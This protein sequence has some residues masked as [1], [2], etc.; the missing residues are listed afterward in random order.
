MILKS[1]RKFADMKHVLYEQKHPGLGTAYWV[2]SELSKGK[3]FNMTILAPREGMKEFPKTFGHYHEAVKHDETETYKL[4]SGKGIF[5]LQKKF[6]D[7]KGTWVPE[8][9]TGVFLVQGYPGDVIM[10]PKEY[11]HSWSNIGDEPLITYDDWNLPHI[12]EDYKYIKKQKGMAYY[13][14]DEKGA[15]RATK[16]SSYKDLPAPVWMSAAEFNAMVNLYY[17]VNTSN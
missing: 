12:P 11:G 1:E 15:I 17:S 2:F 7:E 13:L 10:V 5:M 6:Y 4:L 16:N 3:W 8:K 14:V 9:V